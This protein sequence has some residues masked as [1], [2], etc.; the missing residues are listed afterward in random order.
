MIYM[1]GAVWCCRSGNTLNCT[2]CELTY[3][4]HGKFEMG[5]KLFISIFYSLIRVFFALVAFLDTQT[6]FKQIP[7]PTPTV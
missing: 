1:H 3:L 6:P 7:F 5:F 4:D 2:C